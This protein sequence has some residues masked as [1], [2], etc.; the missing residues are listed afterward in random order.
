MP[1]HYL[2]RRFETENALNYEVR[3][4]VVADGW[5]RTAEDGVE[6]K[7]CR[8]FTIFLA[9]ESDYNPKLVEF[10][11]EEKIAKLALPDSRIVEAVHLGAKEL[12][13]RHTMSFLAAAFP[14]RLDL[15]GDPEL[16]KLTLAQRVKRCREGK[17]DPGLVALMFQY[18]RY[19][20][21]SS[22][23]RG[24]LPANL[25]GIWNN[26]NSPAWHSDYHTNINIQM[27]Y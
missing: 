22:S 5:L 19:L 4:R 18:G 3:A 1:D 12:D 11:R 13:R 15:A 23:A 16:E 27:N 14:V 24:T 7:D 8:D 6:F 25:Q 2:G 10:T 21:L 9:A 26:S 17:S 20:L